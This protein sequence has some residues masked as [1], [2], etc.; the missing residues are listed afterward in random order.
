MLYLV[1]AILVTCS[2]AVTIP[3][4]ETVP[5]PSPMPGADVIGE[6]VMDADGTLRITLF[7]PVHPEHSRLVF[8]P[9]SPDYEFMRV[10]AGRPRP[11]ERSQVFRRLGTVTMNADRSLSISLIGSAQG[12]ATLRSESR[13]G[14]ED[15]SY[16]AILATT[17][18]MEPGDVRPLLP[19][20]ASDR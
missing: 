11:G 18:P 19:N 12:W 13:V 14:P 17:G 15:A 2:Q 8:A 20:Q 6:A 16:G 4:A 5:S 10:Q 1:L 3:D 7:P 9:P